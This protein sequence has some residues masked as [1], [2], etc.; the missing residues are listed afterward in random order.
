MAVYD[1]FFKDFE[2]CKKKIVQLFHLLDLHEVIPDELD[3][4]VGEVDP[5]AEATPAEP[6]DPERAKPI[7]TTPVAPPPVSQAAATTTSA[8]WSSVREAVE[9]TIAETEVMIEAAMKAIRSGSAQASTFE[10]RLAYPLL[11][12][13]FFLFVLETF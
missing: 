13:F 7:E 10:P 8:R 3:G 5:P 4:D 1:A 11:F 6:S 9:Q 2:E 12:L